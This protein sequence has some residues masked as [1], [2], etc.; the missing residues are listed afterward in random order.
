MNYKIVSNNKDIINKANTIFTSLDMNESIHIQEVDF[1]LIDASTLSKT[2]L[3]SYKNRKEYSK[4]LFIVNNDEEITLC[5]QN[6]FPYFLKTN[7]SSNELISW[8]KFLIKDKKEKTLELNDEMILNFES[9][10]IKTNEENIKLTLQEFAL[11]NAINSQNY[12]NTNTLVGILQL[13]S[14]TSVRTI[15]NR[16]RKKTNND[17]I[18]HKRNYGYKLNLSENINKNE[19]NFSSHIKELEEQN[20]LMQEIIDS[21]PVYIVT[22]IHKQLY[23]I[24]KA[25]RDF[26]GTD[27]IKELWDETKGDFFQL[28]KHNSKELETLKTT[29]FSKG[30]HEI[31]LYDFEK[32]DT[33]IFE[34]K[35][36]YFENLDKHLFIFEKK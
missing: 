27:I 35:T 9:K 6:D 11:L 15:I 18:L 23:C 31:E 22:F 13:Q 28:I 29:L 30:L 5:L 20:N 26:L 2:S 14:Q 10:T 36:Y 1:W 4:L 21:S 12:V 33:N 24:N 3:L 25:F 17:L 16:I 19:S 34:V 32:R 8:I 7:F